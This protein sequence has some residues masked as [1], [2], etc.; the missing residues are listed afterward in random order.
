M[1]IKKLMK[2]YNLAELERFLLLPTQPEN[3]TVQTLTILYKR[4]WPE[5]A[6]KPL[7][8]EEKTELLRA[9]EEGNYTIRKPIFRPSYSQSYCIVNIDGN[10]QWRIWS[11]GTDDFALYLMGNC[12]KEEA[13]I[14][15][16]VIAEMLEKFDNVPPSIEKKV[17]RLKA[18]YPPGTKIRLLHMNDIQAPPKGATGTVLHVD[19]AGTIHVAWDTG[20]SLGVIDGVDEIEKI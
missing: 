18:L 16:E 13:D 7:T 17:E 20:E 6:D 4:F 12:F 3:K 10:P 9:I 11:N 1:T 14:N 2:K 15:E 8:E 19:D 5:G